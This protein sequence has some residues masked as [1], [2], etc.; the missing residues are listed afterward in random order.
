M[1]M[2]Q[3]LTTLAMNP[4]KWF[5][6]YNHSDDHAWAEYKSFCRDLVKEMKE[7]RSGEFWRILLCIDDPVLK[8][9]GYAKPIQDRGLS[10]K[11]DIMKALK[12]WIYCEELDGPPKVYAAWD[13]THGRLSELRDFFQKEVEELTRRGHEDPRAYLI[14]QPGDYD[15][16]PADQ[17]AKCK[18]L[19][20]VVRDHY[21]TSSDHFRLY[22]IN[23]AAFEKYFLTLRL[24]EDLTLFSIKTGEPTAKP[25]FC[26]G[27]YVDHIFDK[28]KLQF[29]DTVNRNSS[30][31]ETIVQ[32]FAETVARA[33]TV[34]S[35]MT[36]IQGR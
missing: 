22:S 13:L 7:T 11:S 21:H 18:P 3:V 20:E 8:I 32:F 34:Q 5:N 29:F 27:G 6:Y 19:W 10:S 9:A 28:L 17:R 30:T 2:I 16:L 24:P 36:G 4:Q 23:G 12:L 35:L 14:I 25:V 15:K 31:F 1:A 33:E 26:L